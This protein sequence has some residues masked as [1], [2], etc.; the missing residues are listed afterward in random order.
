MSTEPKRLRLCKQHKQEERQSQYE[1][2]NCDHCKLECELAA[3][4]TELDRL[5]KSLASNKRLFTTALADKVIKSQVKRI[6]Q[7]ED[8]LI[9]MRQQR[10]ML[11]EALE[12]YELGYTDGELARLATCETG[13][14]EISPADANREIR[15]RQALAAVKGGDK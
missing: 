6:E 8:Q 2:H 14:G 5:N 1:P 4:T 13:L 15:R 12:D 9:K 11:A 10:D 7:L 3:K